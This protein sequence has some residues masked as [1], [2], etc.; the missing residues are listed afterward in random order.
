MKSLTKFAI[1]L[2]TAKNITERGGNVLKPF[3]E[4]CVIVES[5]GITPGTFINIDNNIMVTNT[6]MTG[7]YLS[8]PKSFPLDNSVI[9]KPHFIGDAS[10]VNALACPIEDYSQT[11]VKSSVFFENFFSV[12]CW[13]EERFSSENGFSL[14][15]A[16][17]T[18]GKEITRDR[19][20][21]YIQHLKK[22]CEFTPSALLKEVNVKSP[23]YGQGAIYAFWKTFFL[24]KTIYGKVE[25]STFIQTFIQSISIRSTIFTEYL[26]SAFSGL[27]IFYLENMRVIE[28]EK[29][30]GNLFLNTYDMMFE[31][32]VRYVNKNANEDWKKIDQMVKFK[33]PHF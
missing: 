7:D 18:E 17:G 24:Y 26:A 4:S 13:I 20:E 1:G 8:V 14:E 29:N 2:M 25:Q 19:I 15:W 33:R 28:T 31:N 32:L 23:D 10:N 9:P 11:T 6:Q 27:E 22:F 21:D 12:C 30:T 5:N 16:N 3:D